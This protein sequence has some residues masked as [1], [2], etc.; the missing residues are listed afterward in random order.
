MK[1]KL[2]TAIVICAIVPVI[3]WVLSLIRCEMLTQKYYD[4]FS[5]A[6]MQNTMI[7][8][9]E[10]FN[11]LSCNENTAKVYY[12]TKNMTVG[13]VLEF[14]HKNNNWT[15]TSW[16]T[17]WSKTGSASDIIYPYWWHFIYFTF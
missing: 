13:N 11:V 8:D 10:Y 9:I 15:Q 16:N 3:F 4:D 2:I 7:E 14:E 1:K 5:K 12:I 17:I 6:Y